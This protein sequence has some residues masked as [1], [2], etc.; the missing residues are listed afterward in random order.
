MHC[1]CKCYIVTILLILGAIFTIIGVF[2]L[3]F[4][5]NLINQAIKEVRKYY[6]FLTN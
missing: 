5:P 2:A 4:L 6:L 3:L 1:Y